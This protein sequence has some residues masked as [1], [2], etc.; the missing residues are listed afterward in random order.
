VVP[1]SPLS[2]DQ[3]MAVLY[4]IACGNVTTNQQQ[5]LDTEP[6]TAVS[7]KSYGRLSSRAGFPSSSNLK[8]FFDLLLFKA[9][10]GSSIH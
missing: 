3:K 1:P 9:A 7:A 4:A 8:I 6:K 2:V 5:K 10:S